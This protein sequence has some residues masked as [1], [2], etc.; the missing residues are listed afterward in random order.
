MSMADT[1]VVYLSVFVLLNQV[2]LD[3]TPL[4]PA[5]DSFLP[6][7][8]TPDRR[9]TTV[10]SERRRQSFVGGLHGIVECRTIGSSIGVK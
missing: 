5:S 8:L 7:T 1:G 3:V 6:M 4:A 9:Q 10:L 2:F